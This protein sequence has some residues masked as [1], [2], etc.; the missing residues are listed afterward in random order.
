MALLSAVIAGMQ[1]LLC[2]PEAN[3]FEP[4]SSISIRVTPKLAPL[5]CSGSPCWPLLF[6]PNAQPKVDP[7][8]ALIH[9]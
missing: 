7:M 2:T 3:D 5:L 4:S 8:V 9:Q 6:L 1:F